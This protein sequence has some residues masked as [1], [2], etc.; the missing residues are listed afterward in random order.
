MV[1]VAMD[2]RQRILRAAA[3]VYAETGYRGATTRRIASTAGV[4]EITLFRHFGSK[5]ALIHEALR[6]ADVSAPHALPEV[7]ADPPRELR[8]WARSCFERLH[9]RRAVIRKVMGEMGEHPEIVQYIKSNPCAQADELRRYL[10][11]LI[12]RGLADPAV[13]VSAAAAMFLGAVFAGAMGRDAMPE[14]YGQPVHRTVSS[15][16]TLFLRA[17]GYRVPGRTARRNGAAPSR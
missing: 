13:N 17:I 5:R 6:F 3:G 15:Y 9:G 10:R 2:I 16:V 4:N 8:E 14:I 12:A 11:A 7:P 1:L